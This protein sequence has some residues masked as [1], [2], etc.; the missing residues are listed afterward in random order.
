MNTIP[1]DT[2]RDARNRGHATNSPTAAHPSPENSSQQRLN[3]PYPH[4]T[5]L[6]D[7]LLKRKRKTRSITSCYP[8]RQ[9]KVRCDGHV[10]C[11]SCVKRDH[12]ELCQ[13]PGGRG[14]QRTVQSYVSNG[15]NNAFMALEPN[16]GQAQQE[17]G[18]GVELF[19][20]VYIFSLMPIRDKGANSVI[21][22]NDNKQALDPSGREP[23]GLNLSAADALLSRLHGMEEAIS[24]LKT[25]ILTQR[26][27]SAKPEGT[28]C[29]TQANYTPLSSG[30]QDYS[31]G[32][33]D[34]ASPA[35][36]SGRHVVED[37]TGATIYLGSNSEPALL[38][39]C[40][41]GL[42]YGAMEWD[43][44]GKLAATTYPFAN[45]WGG[46]VRISDVLHTLPAHSD[47]MR[48]F[49]FPLGLRFTRRCVSCDH[50]E[51]T[52]LWL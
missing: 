50:G 16:K 11:S 42:D 14:R 48:Y 31:R 45:V 15:D 29:E 27:S 10:P 9:R 33:Q 35:R 36:S 1:A 19:V 4:D 3:S 2:A 18:V 49:A 21:F 23:L 32:N 40:R 52:D 6:V 26:L 39:G 51:S 12:A 13:V 34:A 47:M 7:A 38:L 17:L 24:A 43:S 5:S 37:S 8:C 22:R 44:L 20:P 46:D 25:E 30:G 28:G 41:E